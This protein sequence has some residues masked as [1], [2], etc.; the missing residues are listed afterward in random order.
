MVSAMFTAPIPSGD[1]QAFAGAQV[2]SYPGTPSPMFAHCVG[3]PLEVFRLKYGWPLSEVN[4][5]PELGRML[6]PY[7]YD[8]TQWQAPIEALALH[9]IAHAA[10]ADATAPSDV[11]I[12]AQNLSAPTQAYN[13]QQGYG[14]P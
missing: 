3:A 14:L 7:A 9:G 1:I 11:P 6:D 4:E 2:V 12:A 5:Y 10:Y 13:N 8:N